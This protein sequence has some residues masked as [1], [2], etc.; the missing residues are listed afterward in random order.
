MAPGPVPVGMMRLLLFGAM[1]LV[2]SSAAA[3][4]NC[5]SQK[6]ECDVLLGID[7]ETIVAE[8]DAGGIGGCTLGPVPVGGSWSSGPVDCTLTLRDD[9]YLV[10]A[11]EAGTVNAHIVVWVTVCE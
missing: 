9:G 4:E 8:T 7:G 3:V 6:M 10:A 5:T 1:I 2:A 11:C